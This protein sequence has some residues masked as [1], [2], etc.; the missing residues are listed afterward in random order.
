MN[1]FDIISIIIAAVTFGLYLYILLKKEK[2]KYYYRPKYQ[3]TENII[4]WG[5]TGKY[6]FLEHEGG[7]SLV[8]VDVAKYRQ[9][10]EAKKNKPSKNK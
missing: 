4:E 10:I 5:R 2:P 1:K 7:T 6:K 8:N 9:I 3:H